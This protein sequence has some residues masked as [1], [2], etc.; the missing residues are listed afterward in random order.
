MRNGVLA[1]RARKKKPVQ[2]GVQAIFT[3]EENWKGK[4]PAAIGV[5]SVGLGAVLW[6]WFIIQGTSSLALVSLS[7]LLVTVGV[8][9]CA[10]ALALRK[11]KQENDRLRS[12]LYELEV[13]VEPKNGPTD[14]AVELDPKGDPALVR[15]E[16]RRMSKILALAMAEAIVLI[17]VYAG[18]VQEYASNINMQ[19]WVLANI[20]PGA[21]VLNYNALF[22]V[23]GGVL[24]TLTF[25]LI[26][27]KQ[28]S[29]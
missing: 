5:F 28:G 19:R 6:G 17:M 23:L 11:S 8:G 2:A 4:A 24:G 1:N 10:Y 12:A 22:L 7:I 15:G 21:Y 14:S 27:G 20:W 16:P 13:L 3:V 25:Q 9:L 29:Q 26:L 18:L